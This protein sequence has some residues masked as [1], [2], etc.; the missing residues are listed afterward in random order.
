MIMNDLPYLFCINTKIGVRDDVPE[1]F[2][3]GPGN[4]S[5]PFLNLTT[6]FFYYFTNYYKIH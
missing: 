5:I 3:L 2:N 6:E 1:T 4:I